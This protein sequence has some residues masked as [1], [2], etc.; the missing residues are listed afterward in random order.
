KVKRW[1][2]YILEHPLRDG[3]LGPERGNAATGSNA[4][5]LNIRDP[6]P[7]FIILKALT[8]YQEATGDPR[9][10]PAIQ[11]SL[12]SLDYQLDRRPLFAWNFFRWPDA[13]VTIFWLHER[14]GEVW[15]LNLSRKIVSQG[16]NWPKH[17]SNLPIKD[18][19]RE[20]NWEG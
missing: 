4:P 16:Y 20:W 14:T 6:W 1:V 18:K 7:Q 11:K 10:I 19:S 2:D 9:I 13:L 3:W 8:Q 12:Q 17:F 5:P 15:L